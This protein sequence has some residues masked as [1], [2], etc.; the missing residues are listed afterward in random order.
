[1]LIKLRTAASMYFTHLNNNIINYYFSK[2]TL[3]PTSLENQKK[4]T[5]LGLFSSR[6]MAQI[7]LLL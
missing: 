4:S 7:T 3:V 6:F 1:M 5:L 2:K